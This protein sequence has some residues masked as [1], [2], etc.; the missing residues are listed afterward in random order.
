MR[1]VDLGPPSAND[2][3]S[4]VARKS[5]KREERHSLYEAVD[6]ILG[7][8][9]VSDWDGWVRQTLVAI[10]L[11]IRAAHPALHYEI[12]RVVRGTDRPRGDFPTSNRSWVGAAIRVDLA[13]ADEW[14]ATGEAALSET[15]PSVETQQ[16]AL[17]ALLRPIAWVALHPWLRDLAD[18][19]GALSFGEVPPIMAPSSSGLLAIGK[20]RTAWR[21]R[22][23]TVRWVE[24]QAAARN[25]KTEKEAYGFVATQFGKKK[26]NYQVIQEWRAD[27]AR[28][29]GSAYVREALDLSRRLGERAAAIKRL[30]ASGT[31]NDKARD[32]LL[33]LE[34]TYSENSLK[35]LAKSFKALPRKK[36][37]IGK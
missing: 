4:H 9:D 5:P 11:V 29:L 22:L 26:E 3:E 19:L 37:G 15:P 1:C 30:V 24:F 18:G 2:T 17:A 13:Q 36:L 32:E 10:G 21:L 23:R 16:R 6:H 31:A 35:E 27:A 14:I 25:F 12:G 20:G 33:F 34:T 8:P 28:M 7:G